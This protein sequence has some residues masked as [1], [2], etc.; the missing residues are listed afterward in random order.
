MNLSL[1]IL[2]GRL[3]VKQLKISRRHMG[4]IF[5]AD[6]RS[7][8][9][10]GS[11]IGGKTENRREKVEIN[12]NV[13]VFPS[14]PDHDNFYLVS[15]DPKPPLWA[16]YAMFC[17]LFHPDLIWCPCDMICL[18]R[19]S[20]PLLPPPPSPPPSLLPPTPPPPPTLSYSPGGRCISRQGSLS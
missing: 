2:D 9:P 4:S 18:C 14:N 3:T 19:W 8:R 16:S 11:V 7:R 5:K 1:A 15:F 12:S 10:R 6:L 17:D 20:P 13:S